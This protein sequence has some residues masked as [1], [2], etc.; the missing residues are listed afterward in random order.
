MQRY[1]TSSWGDRTS[2][3]ITQTWSPASFGCHPVQVCADHRV[4]K[5]RQNRFEADCLRAGASSTRQQKSVKLSENRQKSAKWASRQKYRPI[6]ATRPSFWAG[7]REKSG[8]VGKSREKS[9][10]GRQ[11]FTR[12]VG[13]KSRQNQSN[14][15][16]NP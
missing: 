15:G 13:K 5:S 3:C 1:E 8:K 4:G 12:P 2:Q 14:F 6:S 9:G 7:S 11:N 10:K 16:D